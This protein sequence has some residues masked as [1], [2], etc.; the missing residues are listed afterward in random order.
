MKV[1]TRYTFAGEIPWSSAFAEAHRTPTSYCDKVSIGGRNKLE[2]ETLAHRYVW[3]NYC[4]V[5]HPA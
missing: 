2:I 3:E 1:P 4:T 5:P